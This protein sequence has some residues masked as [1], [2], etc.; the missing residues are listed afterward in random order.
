MCQAPSPGLTDTYW[1]R[2]QRWV[3]VPL[4]FAIPGHV[5]STVR[6]PNVAGTIDIA[7][8]ILDLAGLPLNP[9]H[10][11]ASLLDGRARLA[12]F[13]TDYS[14]PLAGLEDGCWKYHFQIDRRSSKLF[15]PCTDPDERD[16][17]AADEAVRVETYRDRVESWARARRA[18]IVGAK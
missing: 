1:P 2:F 5:M 6:V 9:A 13:Y 14:L 10:E 7:P 8:T 15:D 3:R 12:F 16:D 17:R 11:G 4:F 18:A